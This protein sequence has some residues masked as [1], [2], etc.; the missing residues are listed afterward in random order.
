MQFCKLGYRTIVLEDILIAEYYRGMK[1]KVGE[2]GQITIPKKLR[3]R[4]GV[5]QGME[6]ELHETAEGIVLRKQDLANLRDGQ[7]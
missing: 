7:D 6:L 5:Q 1:T 3:D 4:Y 2:R